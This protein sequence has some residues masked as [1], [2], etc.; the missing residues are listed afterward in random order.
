MLIISLLVLL[1]IIIKGCNTY[2]EIYS[3]ITLFNIANI[4]N[5]N[6]LVTRQTSHPMKNNPLLIVSSLQP[7]HSL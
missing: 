4:N 3:L 1:I 7:Q 5:H 2:T 6:I